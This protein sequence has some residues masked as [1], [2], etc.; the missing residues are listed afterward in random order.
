MFPALA[1]RF[2]TTES[3]GEPLG[4]FKYGYVVFHELSETLTY[5]G[6]NNKYNSSMYSI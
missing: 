3:P 1:G 4:C 6:R 2:F 5:E